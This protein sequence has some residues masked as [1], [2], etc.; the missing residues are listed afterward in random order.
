MLFFSLVERERTSGRLKMDPPIFAN[1]IS[2]FDYL[3]G[4]NRKIFNH[5]WVNF[6]LGNIY[7]TSSTSKGYAIFFSR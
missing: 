6:P 1:L 3:E 7:L 2:S 4:C 5:G